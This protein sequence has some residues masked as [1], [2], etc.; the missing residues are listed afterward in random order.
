MKDR[1][2]FQP[3]KVGK[4]S[5]QVVEN[6]KPF[7]VNLREAMFTG[8]PQTNYPG[9]ISVTQLHGP[10]GEMWMSDL[11]CE[12]VQMHRELACHARG[13]VLVGGLGLGIVARMAARYKRVKEITVVELAREVI[14]LVG[15]SLADAKI[16]IQQGEIHAFARNTKLHFDVAL[17]DT[18]AG[19]GE[20]VWQE[21]VVPLRRALWGKAKMVF[22]WQERVMLGQVEDLG[23]APADVND[24]LRP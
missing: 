16:K 24:R 7:V 22:C 2:Q 20:W 8:L 17:L 6:E 1:V 13:R 9:P 15:P 14:D 23:I 10:D 21:D 11:P 3:H 4:Y 5:L 19:T 18:W 12:L